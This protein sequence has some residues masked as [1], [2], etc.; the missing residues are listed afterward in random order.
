[1]LV[2]DLVL[3]SLVMATTVTVTGLCGFLAARHIH[4]MPLSPPT[5]NVGPVINVGF[6]NSPRNTQAQ[7]QRQRQLQTTAAASANNTSPSPRGRQVSAVVESNARKSTARKPSLAPIDLSTPLNV[8]KLLQSLMKLGVDAEDRGSEWISNYE[9][10]AYLKKLNW[11]QTVVPKLFF[12]P[13]HASLLLIQLTI[14]GKLIDV[15]DP[16]QTSSV[17]HDYLLLIHS[18]TERHFYLIFIDSLNKKIVAFDTLHRRQD[19]AL[20]VSV[21][22][23]FP[24]LDLTALGY[25]LTNYTG[26]MCKQQSAS[27]GPWA[28]WLLTAVVLNYQNCRGTSGSVPRDFDVRPLDA[29]SNSDVKAF[30]ETVLK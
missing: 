6:L 2:Q 27:C 26:V 19:P 23:M 28:A 10:E 9:V 1:M 25:T 21:A 3:A 24:D 4:R 12:R 14:D 30:W 29:C 5:L 13:F 17:D 20:I 18:S 22:K 15:L 8:G 11:L 7:R 16:L